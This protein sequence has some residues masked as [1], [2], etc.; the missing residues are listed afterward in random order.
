[1]KNAAEMVECVFV[2]HRVFMKNTAYSVWKA[3][4]LFTRSVVLLSSY[5]VLCHL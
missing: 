4:E 2:L 3:L 1:M 5:C